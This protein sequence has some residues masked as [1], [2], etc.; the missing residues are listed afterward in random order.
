MKLFDKFKKFIAC[1]ILVCFIPSQ[2]WAQGINIPA[3]S[4]LNLNTGQLIV[5]GDVN[6][7][8]TLTT[9]TG[10]ITLT[11]NWTNSGTFHSGTGTVN[12]SAP[13]GTQ[14]VNSGGAAANDAFFD[15][16]HSTASTVQLNSN[17]I[18]INDN[19]TNTS[20]TFDANNLNM[21]VAGNW[22]NTAAFTPG[23]S[24]VTLNGAN[25]SNQDV[26]GSTT[27]YNFSKVNTAAATLTFDAAGTQNFTNS[28]T[29]Q[30]N[31]AGNLLSILS[32]LPGTQARINLGA[33]AP[34]LIN[35]VNVQD[36]NAGIP[37]GNQTLVA[38][39]FSAG[40]PTQHNTNWFF[41]NVTVTWT[42]AVSTDWNNPA[43]W[44]PSLVPTAGDSVLVP[45]V[46]NEPIF[47]TNVTV[48]GLTIDPNA[49]VNINGFNI[50]VSS[51]FVNNGT[52]A[53]H[54]NE[55]TVSLTQDITDPGT[56]EYLGDGTSNPITIIN[57]PGASNYYNLLINDTNPT[58]N[59][60]VSNSAV[61][62]V[63]NVTVTSGTMNI[64]T[65]SDTLTVGGTL[66]V[67]NAS[68]TLTATNGNIAANGPVSITAGTFTAPGSG[69]SFTVAGD[70]TNTAGN[71][72]PITHPTGF[73]NS[74]G[75]VTLNG[76]NQTVLGTTVFY[77]FT[78]SVTSPESL[79]FDA[80]GG[81]LQTF[82]NSLTLLGNSAVNLLTINS[83][84]PGTQADIIL[85][86][87]GAQNI[88]YV[89]VQ[90]SNAGTPP[91]NQ[92][93]VA[94]H[95]SPG[96]PAQNN[97]NWFFGVA[98][99]TWNGSISNDWNTAGNW[100]P[101][102]VPTS[103][104]T[105]V[106][107]NGVGITFQP[108]LFSNV[109]VA[110]LTIDSG[111][112]LTLS[113][114][115]LSVTPLGPGSFIND[116]TVVLEGNEVVTLTM[117]STHGTFEYVGDGNATQDTRTLTL[118]AV[119]CSPNVA[120]N[121]LVIN[122][123]NVTPANRDIFASNGAV[124]V[125]GNLT[126][127]SGT[128]DTSNNNSSLAANGNVTITTPGIFKAPG[129][130]RTFTV[131]GNFANT[132]TFNNS[133]GLVT[134]NGTNQT[135]SGTS[136]FYQFAKVVSSA[137]TLTFD[138]TGLQTFT[139]SLTMQGAPLQLLS[140][141]SDLVGT[142]ADIVLTAGG[143]QNISEV[144]VQYSNA[145]TLP[146]DL[147]LIARNNSVDAPPGGTN[148]N[149]NFG[150]PTVTWTGT[151]STD[152][153]NPLNWNLGIV[154]IAGDTAIIANAPNQPILTTPV[155]V[156]ALTIN[157]G[158]TV[159]LNGNNL[160]VDTTA[161]G[162]GTLTNNGTLI[163]NGPET[164]AITTVNTNAGT[165][166]YVGDNTGATYNITNLL[167]TTNP[168]NN[169]FY[170]LVINDTHGT[171]DTFTTGADPLTVD[172]NLSVTKGTLDLSASSAVNVVGAVSI[173]AGSTL[174]GPSATTLTAFDVGGSWT[175][176]GTYVNDSGAVTLTTTATATITGNT[177]F[178]DLFSNAAGKTVLFAPGSDQTVT[179]SFLFTGLA[180]SLISLL[181]ATTGSPWNIT[182]PGG[183]QTVSHLNVEDSNALTN[184]ITCVN[185]TNSLDN[186]ANWIFSGFRIISPA[187]L[188]TV[189]QVPT[190][191]GQGPPNSPIYIRDVS[192]N[193][194]ATTTA[195]ANGYFRVMVGQDAANT[196]LPIT[197]Q[198]AIQAN[199]SLTPYVSPALTSPGDIDT[200]NVV[201]SPT[202][203]QVPVITQINGNVITNP[204][205]TQIIVGEKP[206][207]VGQGLANQPVTLQALDASGN[208][209]LAVGSG[210]V[211][212]GGT[213]SV[214]ATTALP[215]ATNFLSITVGVPTLET[216][217]Y[218]IQV[219]LTDPFGIVFN[220]VTN[221]PIQGAQVTVYSQATKLPATGVQS[222][223]A[224]SVCSSANPYTTL[225]DGFYSFLVPPGQYYLGISAP[226]YLY[227]SKIPAVPAGRSVVTGSRGEVFT[228]GGTVTE[229]DQPLD[230]NNMLLRITKTANKSE[231]VVGDIV[232][233]TVNI[234]NLSA[235]N[236]VT[237]VYLNDQIPPG[238]KYIKDRV[239]LNGTATSEPNGQRPLM[240]NVGTVAAGTTVV[241]QYQLVIGT[242]VTMG[243][244]QNTARAEYLD[245]LVISNPAQASVKIILDPVFDLGT[246]IGKVFF[247][248]NENGIQDP[249]YFD[250]ISHQTTI[251]KP[252]PNVQ[253]VMED[254][255]V[256]TTDRDGKFSIPGLLPG[257][258]L[259]RL[260]E[261]TLPPGAYLTTDKAMI[262]D[263]TAGSIS[264]VNFGVNIDE[265]QTKGRDAVFF[266]EKIR[267]TQDRN[268]PVPR[269]NAAL[270]D[271]SS[272]AKPG[273]EE[274][275]LN[276]GALVR[277][278]EFRIFTNY[279][280]F[281]ANWR[282][283]IMDADT[284]KVIRSF[285][286]TAANINDPIYWDG[287]DSQGII[288]YPDHKYSYAVTV[289]DSNNNHD[290][291]KENLI[292]VRE[293][294]DDLLLKKER[295]E[296]KDILKDRATRYRQW[297]DVQGSVNNL[298]HQLIHIQGETI[299]LDRQGTEVKSIHVMKGNNL[300]M[301][302]PM[303]EQYGL[304]PSELMAAGFSTANEKDNLEVILPNGD[305]SL[306]V[307]S[308]K[309][310][311]GS[312]PE[313]VA[314]GQPLPA[315][316]GMPS[317]ILSAS[318]PGS[319]EHY[320]R[321]LKVGDDYMMFVA[322]GDAQVGYNIDRGNIEPIQDKTQQP[323]FYKEGKGAYYLKGQ[324]LGKYLITSSF[325]S[326]RAQKAMFR[327][328]DPNTYYPVYGDSSTINYD[329]ADT[330]GALYLKVEWD[331]SS[332]ILGNYV[333]DFH[334]TEFAAF[335]QKY[336]GGKLDYQ[337]VANNPYGDAR[338]K[339]VV[340]HAQ[341]QQLPSHNE[342]LAT[343]GSLYFLKYKE[344]IQGSDTVTIQVRDQTTGLVV[345]SQTL[346]NGAD[347][348]LDNSQG[349]I[350]FWQPVAMIAQSESIISN[351]LING[352][353]IYVVV[354][355]QFAV[356]GLQMQGA[357]GARVAQ[358]V[359]NNIVLGGTYI[360]DNSAG[361]KY[362]LE[363]TDATLHVNKDAT[364]K[365]EY[366]KTTSQETGSY[367][368]TDGGISFTPLML[369]NS[370]S[371]IA[372]GIKGDARLFDNI[373]VKT[374]Y[375]WIGNDFGATDT[376]Y[377]QGTEKMGMSMTFDLTPVTRLT[378]S[379]DIQR[380][381]A[382]NN[383]Q[384]STQIGASETDTTMVQI[385]HTQEKLKLT[386][387]FQ[388]VET[389]SVINGV[390]STT[391]Q[392][393]ATIG[394]QAQYDLTN[395]IK[396]TLGQQVDVQNPNNTATTLGVAAR[397]T[398]M[399]TLN[400]LEVF[401]P[402]GHA[403]TAGMTNQLG[404]KIAL[405]TNYT[406]TNLNTGVVD[407]TASV[408]VS[409][410]INNN[411]TA[412]S[413]I[414]T[415]ASSSGG[416]ITTA[417]VGAKAKLA[418]GMSLDMNVGKTQNALGAQG[419]STVSLNGTTQIGNTTITGTAQGTAQGSGGTAALNPLSVGTTG[420][421]SSLVPSSTATAAATTSFGVQAVTKVNEMTT[422]NG[423]VNVTND[424]TGAQTTTFGFGNTSKL[425]QE[426]QA[427]TSNSFSFS[428]SEGTTD[429]SK[430]G[431]VRTLN[432]HNLE[433]DFTKQAANQPTAITQSNIFG[434]S[435]DVN[436]KLALNASIERGKVQNLGTS[437]TN[438][439]DFT[440]GA[441]YV[442]K[443]TA[444]AEARLK[445]SL[446]LELRVD[447]GVGTD[448]L[449]QYVL[450]DAIEGKI[451]DNFSVNAKVDYSKTLDTT[452][453]AVAERH[454][455]IILGTAYRPVNFD[456][457]NLIA[458]YSYQS[459]YGGGLQQADALN[460]NVQKTVAQ[461][462]SGEAVY[463]IND[464]W[465]AAEKIAY[466][467][468]NEQ[469]TGF[470]FTQTHTWL[471]IQRLSYKID[472]DWTLTGEYRDLG[473]V[474]AKD[475]KQGILLQATRAINA[476]TELSIGWNFTK[477]SDDLTNLSYTSMGPFV[478][479]T[480]K[481]YDESPEQRARARAKWLDARISEW[482]WILIRKEFSKKDSKIV[483]ELNRMF[484]LA[485]A[486]RR[487]GRLEESRQIYKDIITAGQMMYDEAS[488]YIRGRI[489]FEE[490]LQKLDKSA[491]EYFKG[492][493]YLK[494][495]KIWEKVVDD[496]SKGVV[497]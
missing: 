386:G 350:L 330:Q 308:V 26:L 441:G 60:F 207:L 239:L 126:V 275:V 442:L 263:I 449:R 24:T 311:G 31:S 353:P 57:F 8:G 369:N 165:F 34:Q 159:T 210:T 23:T 323:G 483:L 316:S 267:L 36:S 75:T 288:I 10:P 168:S 184:T 331:K 414:A 35:F 90:D 78:K 42:G 277:Q 494:A 325:D 128:L 448:S 326:D 443:D 166:E 15:L 102:V 370:A 135:V 375:K 485:K 52:L 215:T 497:K 238:F 321:P 123:P 134:L 420:P 344:V 179:N 110:G 217:S 460:T 332:A 471:V 172:G 163:L 85:P 265:S 219:S 141:R 300:F 139:N 466:R 444:T 149:W 457:L 127:S 236:D 431:L 48:A 359:G 62:T 362:T 357:Q 358:A 27:F 251:E 186:N 416:N 289:T 295:E 76:S 345:A 211:T 87:T 47:S 255:T 248:W 177:T 445:N 43:N 80:T 33:V 137:A 29:M 478:R 496:A 280:P 170:N 1:A 79:T 271:A 340:Y 182:V 98:T 415:T 234:Q 462:F 46:A 167:T 429:S 259:F 230:A 82:T 14:S 121:N 118:C 285:E 451:T 233:Y 407:R 32:T 400:A 243:N 452:T 279:S 13:G 268:R 379:E 89:N 397:V 378:A 237:N 136:T 106:I 175:N 59:T 458:E 231:A 391:N 487:A 402:Q 17:A 455:E 282:L 44:T 472:R 119:S 64:S 203:N 419:A 395:R 101:A 97:T 212:A 225:A 334:D 92:T 371:G 199:N 152:W 19:F 489:D 432:G 45:N 427:V 181:S 307:V 373:G 91:G 108:V 222:C 213:Y 185:C 385:V 322:L 142:Q 223:N 109:T 337:S 161:G 7:A 281:I 258:H 188:T 467:I 2:A 412:T 413:S 138:H 117:D 107:P 144:N 387:Q 465:Q 463:D 37:P 488:E 111:S 84:N 447:R 393:G 178:Y 459:G 303:M 171:P 347:Y 240:F 446:K 200:F 346:K 438:R 3:G 313:N 227:P 72:V 68:G 479:M 475:N 440:L 241:L 302:I 28:L 426:L 382:Y 245:G 425:D 189:G 339:L 190:I 95:F 153:N 314:E 22:E 333:V 338:T 187:I 398:D 201:A 336:Y 493:E 492:G 192:G 377:Q 250:P 253:I 164:V 235:V 287:R 388:L 482:A 274:V 218:I 428:P 383:L 301:D 490:Q 112:T 351:N 73:N 403:I 96:S 310:N 348:E 151:V 304:T 292:T 399:T 105:V 86:S 115:N 380:L 454:Q 229:I 474:E 4:S 21:N 51:T 361:Q 30:G 193:L 5:P 430:Y 65:N 40:S 261:R 468:Q 298:N 356:S 54:G 197:P 456:N 389:K 155:T 100:S 220:S 77:N 103:G 206:T 299:H 83:T 374:Y 169:V 315:S 130:G 390:E 417:S 461:V 335:S 406:L 283:D 256:I 204:A 114:F 260:D 104:D 476:N 262:A 158:S 25:G 320:S 278:A 154:P 305:Y 306:D 422:T 291:T 324:I 290:D 297:L 264:K 116:G 410:Q 20:G 477:Y 9:T 284:S 209:L 50:T 173:G 294:K 12:F 148:T 327:Q 176:N 133:N 372:Y 352:D 405:T 365:A 423:S 122:D 39:V 224:A 74:N 272:N 381:L 16:T 437:Q 232:M 216:T 404:K 473:Q 66:A 18:A 81:V 486:S 434:L 6:N 269:L 49:S 450:Y 266:N 246:V 342:F 70:F 343:G 132:G 411:L 160:T 273:T 252:V 421:V 439:T 145:G 147:T 257:R 418:E 469:D 11:G 435:G 355:Y 247:D 480:G 58:K 319:L 396:L 424:T 329:A 67:N 317:R 495:R 312:S 124:T 194:V 309:S 125:N 41:G 195:D 157:S 296:D 408:M 453:K 61:K 409:D 131:T 93:L 143:I 56:F 368:S 293:I 363:G 364:I 328:L 150:N 63:G 244:Y 214:T 367:V 69:K 354:D 202:T 376:T 71:F 191:I 226:G 88:D 228:V 341:T 221:L 242:G 286:G 208:L 384:T 146:A 249:P 196:H 205:L 94:R 360:Q 366:A 401:S 270:F 394:G 276:E 491:R 53:L 129:T 113:G 484:A 180:A 38:H 318:G 183:P 162:T 470:Q 174:K 99:V 120:Y 464:Q 349:R 481:F 392:R 198:L 140:I 433:A 156:G 436:D 55:A 254:G